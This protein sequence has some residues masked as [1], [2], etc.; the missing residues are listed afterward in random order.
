MIY[1]F[2]IWKCHEFSTSHYIN[3][4]HI[5]LCIC[6]FFFFCWLLRRRDLSVWHL[7]FRNELALDS[8]TNETFFLLTPVNATCYTVTT[9]L[10]QLC[11]LRAAL[12]SNMYCKSAN[13]YP[14]VIYENCLDRGVE[15]IYLALL[16]LFVWFCLFLLI[17]ILNCSM[18]Q[19]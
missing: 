13:T 14:A 5:S 10:K 6:L 12:P 19:N 2:N 11:T 17:S 9:S 18:V 15:I 16:V 4:L 7:F 8:I 1:T 3:S